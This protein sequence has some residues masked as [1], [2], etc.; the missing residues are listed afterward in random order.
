MTRE[1]RLHFAN[2]L[3]KLRDQL[4]I[5]FEKAEQKK[6]EKENYRKELLLIN[7]LMLQTIKVNDVAPNVPPSIKNWQIGISNSPEIN[8]ESFG[9]VWHTS[10]KVAKELV[11]FYT[12]ESSPKMDV[13]PFRYQENEKV[14]YLILNY[15]FKLHTPFSGH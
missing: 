11:K 13:I 3:K 5:A 15:K 6:K 14:T 1:E 9:A 8:T 12:T 10:G 7:K 4:K 2:E